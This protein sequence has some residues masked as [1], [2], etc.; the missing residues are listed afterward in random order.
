M[1]IGF[2]ELIVIAIVALLV[3]G[4]KRLPEAGRSLG[5]GIREFKDGINGKPD[6][7]LDEGPRS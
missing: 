3:M 1:P 2:P 7:G 5:H 6:D 4:P